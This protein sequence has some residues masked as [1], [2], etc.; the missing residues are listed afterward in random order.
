MPARSGAAHHIECESAEHDLH[1]FQAIR[2]MDEI[3]VANHML[4]HDV[5]RATDYDLWIADEG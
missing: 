1:A 2:R 5:T 4:F 3:L